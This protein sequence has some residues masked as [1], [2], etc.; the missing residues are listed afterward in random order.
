M[1]FNTCCVSGKKA[2]HTLPHG[3]PVRLVLPRFVDG[4]ALIGRV[5]LASW[6]GCTM[7]NT[8]ADERAS[9]WQLWPNQLGPCT[10]QC[11]HLLL[12]RNAGQ[13][14]AKTGGQY[15]PGKRE[16]YYFPVWRKGHFSDKSNFMKLL[17]TLGKKSL[18]F[19]FPAD[20]RNLVR[21]SCV[22]SPRHTWGAEGWPGLPAWRSPRPHTA[23]HPPGRSSPPLF[24]EQSASR[25]CSAQ[26]Q[27]ALD[28]LHQNSCIK[29]L[30]C[31]RLSVCWLAVLLMSF[32]YASPW[33]QGLGP[34][35]GSGK[36]EK[37]SPASHITKGA[38]K[39]L[40]LF[41]SFTAWDSA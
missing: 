1:Q 7:A 9:T 13:R 25:Q 12:L 38:N 21:W 17:L 37:G 14:G 31:T 18:S 36:P 19:Y 6:R 2:L 27:K 5:T 10:K 20:T 24:L 28:F 34:V 32:F 11:C 41:S 23:G 29:A 8:R 33:P 4:K 16:C 40:V 30:R 22:R 35:P 3:H 39:M 15:T 26:G